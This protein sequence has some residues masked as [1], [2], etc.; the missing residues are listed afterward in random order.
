M[1]V[2]PWSQWM[3]L[4]RGTR[5]TVIGIAIDANNEIPCPIDSVIYVSE[6]GL[7]YHRRVDEFLCKFIPA[8]H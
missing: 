6:E 4:K 5:Y 3:N 8:V 2:L 1:N 7:I